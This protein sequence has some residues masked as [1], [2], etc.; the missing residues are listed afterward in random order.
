M[1]RNIFWWQVWFKFRGEGSKTSR[2]HLAFLTLSL[3]LVFDLK[4]FVQRIL[5]ARETH[6]TPPQRSLPWLANRCSFHHFLWAFCDFA[7]SIR[8][9]LWACLLVCCC[10]PWGRAWLLMLGLCT[11]LAG[12]RHSPKIFLTEWLNLGSHLLCL[13]CDVLLSPPCHCWCHSLYGEPFSSFFKKP[14]LHIWMPT[15]LLTGLLSTGLSHIFASARTSHL[16]STLPGPLLPVSFHELHSHRVYPLITG[17]TLHV[18]SWDRLLF[19]H[20][21]NLFISPLAL[22]YCLS[23]FHGSELT[24]QDPLPATH[25]S[26]PCPDLPLI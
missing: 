26:H 3:F 21:F 24:A 14:R 8:G 9:E 4:V 22:R 6:Q 13:H 16:Q 5:F 19:T 1:L 7:V 18:A 23:E 17:F 10:F 12:N 15:L 11:V 20:S 25:P 2:F